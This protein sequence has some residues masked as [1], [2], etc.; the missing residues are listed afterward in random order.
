MNV[1]IRSSLVLCAFFAVAV[2]LSSCGGGKNSIEAFESR[3]QALE[4]SGTPDSLL[5]SIR[6]HLSQ[7]KAGKRTS[8]GRL[9][10][11][12]IDSLKVRTAAAEQW[13]AEITQAK[14]EH[15]DGLYTQL[16]EKKKGLSGL[17]LKE[18]DSLLG[19][20]DS[21]IKKNW[22]IQAVRFVDE[23]D[24]LMP[25]LVK[26]EEN[27]RKVL[28]QLSG[29][30]SVTKKLTQNT[31][32]AVEKK[33]VTFLKEGTFEMEE[34]MQGKTSPTLKEDWHFISSGTYGVK[35]DTILLA[36]KNEKC[37][38]ETYWNLMMKG[39]KQAWVK[40]DKKKPYDTLITD[41]SKDRFFTFEYLTD[42]FRKK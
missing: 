35:G 14:K 32:N 36:V 20:A 2:V 13:Y 6:V 31:A 29:T 16:S 24:S 33:R 41:G 15:V 21:F 9:L 5:S 25:V 17:Q 3:L 23:L 10:R 40:N 8:N 12:S 37:F 38:K 11:T 1:M 27:A 18:A 4:T 34:S 39:S 42:E 19:I 28:S 7:A 30:W 26:D 22:Y